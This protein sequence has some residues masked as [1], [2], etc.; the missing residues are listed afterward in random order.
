MKSFKSLFSRA[1]LARSPRTS[2]GT[3]WTTLFLMTLIVGCATSLALSVPPLGQ[4]TLY[5]SNKKPGSVYFWYCVKR[6]FFGGECKEGHIDYY[7]LN[8]AD[9]RQRLI[10]MGYRLV[11]RGRKF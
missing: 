8:K 10:D 4:R 9:E 11:P 5:I 1:L 7:D 3:T 2:A 6:E